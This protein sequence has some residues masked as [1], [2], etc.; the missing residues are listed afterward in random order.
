MLLLLTISRL[1]IIPTYMKSFNPHDLGEKFTLEACQR[2]SINNYLRK[3]KERLKHALVSAEIEIGSLAIE[4]TSSKTRFDGI[5]LWFK[6]PKCKRRSGTLFV[7]PMSREV[8]CRKCL[9]LEY[10]S[11]RFR[12]MAENSLNIHSYDRLS[13]YGKTKSR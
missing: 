12:G 2:L 1:M 9:N 11:R 6:C 5:R 7:H 10:R 8:G 4:L 13:L 3:A